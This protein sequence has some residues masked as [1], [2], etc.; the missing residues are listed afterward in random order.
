MKYHEITE[1]EREREEYPKEWVHY[2]DCNLPDDGEEILVYTGK[3]VTT[4]INYIDDGYYL[5]S[6]YDWLDIVAWMP[7]PEYR[8]DE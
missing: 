6:G 4:D 7:I 1:Q 3:Y 2:L 5:D 8:G